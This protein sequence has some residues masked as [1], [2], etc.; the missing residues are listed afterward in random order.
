MR[1][2]VDMD[3][4]LAKWN[5]VSSDQ[6]LEQGYYRN[7]EA[8]QELVDEVNSL[9]SQGEDVYILSCYLTDSEYAFNEKKEWIKEYLPELSEEKYILIPYSEPELDKDGNVIKDENG[10]VKMVPTNKAEYL[11]ENYS[12]ITSK[13]YLIDDYTKN[14]LEWKAMGG[15][16]VKYLNG[17]N[18]TKGTWK[19]LCIDEKCSDNG[20]EITFSLN[21]IILSE[22]VKEFGVD[23]ISVEN[24]NYYQFL[25][26]YKEKVYSFPVVN[27][28]YYSLDK[29]ASLIKYNINET[30]SYAQNYARHKVYYNFGTRHNVPPHLYEKIT[31]Y[32]SRNYPTLSKC[33]DFN[34]LLGHLDKENLDD[35]EYTLFLYENTTAMGIDEDGLYFNSGYEY[36]EDNSRI[37]LSYLEWYEAMIDTKELINDV[38]LSSIANNL[39]TNNCEAIKEVTNFTTDEELDEPDICDED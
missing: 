15:V 33:R 21:M 24:G 5:N 16:G 36:L 19:G 25:I 20:K 6:L 37:S 39:N 18:H 4:T 27:D 30:K 35:M 10:K 9:I 7:L 8:N 1:I 13:D 14:L 28:K 32:Y 12:P 31:Q 3:G 11:K 17:I 29:Y 23:L 2:F 34:Y 38:Q 26:A 22:K